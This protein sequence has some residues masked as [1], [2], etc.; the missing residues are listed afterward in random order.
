MPS[1]KPMSADCRLYLVTPPIADAA[2]FVPGLA[3]ACAA[4]DIAAVLIILAEADERAQVGRIKTLAPVAQAAGAAAIVAA[5]PA[6]AM[7]GG[8]DGAHIP[9]DDAAGL[10]AAVEA[11][12]PDRI[13]GAGRLRSRHA[14]MSA[15]EAGVDYVMFGEPRADGSLP[16]FDLVAERAAWWAALFT[17]PC[18]AFA[19]SLEDIPALAATGSEFVALGDAVWLHPDGA[20]AAVGK[21]LA[22]IATAELAAR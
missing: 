4:G 18:V 13:V 19:R 12:Q 14:A 15:G 6:V 1:H 16:A 21:A 7:R 2:A 20:A 5:S 11:L 10:R 8:A 3:A 17:V 9:G 22:A